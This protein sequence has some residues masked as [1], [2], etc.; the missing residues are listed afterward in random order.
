MR[1]GDVETA[2]RQ[3]D[4]LLRLYFIEIQRYVL[5]RSVGLKS[6]VLCAHASEK[7]EKTRNTGNNNTLVVKG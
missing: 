4:R 6:R 5:S 7:P 2:I 3:N 1:Y